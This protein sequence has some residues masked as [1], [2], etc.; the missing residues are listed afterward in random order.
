M[1]RYYIVV[2]GQVQ[3]VGFRYF[4]YYNAVRL[5]ITG[6]VRNCYNGDVDMEIQGDEESLSAFIK[7]I[8]KGNG[9]S[10]IQDI[11]VKSIDIKQ[12]ERSFKIYG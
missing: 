7:I 1:E 4:A 2:S 6:W 10:S 5:N 11:T 3:G 12:K 8:K 9:Y